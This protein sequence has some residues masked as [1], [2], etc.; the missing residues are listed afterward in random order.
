MSKHP[1]A[2]NKHAEKPAD[3]RA[4]SYIHIRCTAREKAAWVKS[5]GGKLSPWVIDALNNAASRR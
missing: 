3:E 5:A 4:D 1:N 2:G